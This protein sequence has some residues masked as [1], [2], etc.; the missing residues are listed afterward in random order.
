VAAAAETTEAMRLKIVEMLSAIGG[1]KCS[2]GDSD[3]S[4]EH[5]N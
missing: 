3:E 1:Q 2:T 5:L 4:G